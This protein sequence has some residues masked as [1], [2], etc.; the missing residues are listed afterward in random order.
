M[1]SAV[2]VLGSDAEKAKRRVQ[3]A[4]SQWLIGKPALIAQVL[5]SATTD[6][7]AQRIVEQARTT[8]MGH[9]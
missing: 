7:E 9:S 5:S 3:L 8:V 1:G 6:E 4:E 2:Q